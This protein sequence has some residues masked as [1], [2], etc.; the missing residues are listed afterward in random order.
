MAMDVEQVISGLEALAARV[1][2][3]LEQNRR[4]KSENQELRRKRDEVRKE[5]EHLIAQVGSLTEAPVKPPKSKKRERKAARTA[6]R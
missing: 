3:L 5:V 2:G 1:D 6:S 4:L